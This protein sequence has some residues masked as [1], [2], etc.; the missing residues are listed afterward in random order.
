MVKNIRF[1]PRVLALLLS[2][3]VVIKVG[4]GSQIKKMNDVYRVK[5]YLIDFI[6]DDGYVDF[7]SISTQYD[8]EDFNGEYLRI[9][10][11]DMNISFV[12][13][14]DVYICDGNKNDFSF[15]LA[16]NYDNLLGYDEEGNP[17]YETFDPIK[18]NDETGVKYVY[19]QGFTL[20]KVVVKANPIQV[21]DLDDYDINVSSHNG[22]SY[23]LTLNE[24]K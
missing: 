6:T 8:I 15:M 19:P 5:G 4:I 11:E 7:S 10:L 22:K 23:T 16:F 21:E 2:A 12:R 14:N 17:V 24:N 9:A 13:M 3:V 20:K 1:G 18:I